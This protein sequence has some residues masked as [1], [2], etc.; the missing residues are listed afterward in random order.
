MLYFVE[1][2]MMCCIICRYVLLYF[3]FVGF[4]LGY[5]N[6][7]CIILRL[8]DF[9]SFMFCLE[10]VLFEKFLILGCY[11]NFLMMMFVL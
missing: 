6:L 2:V 3:F 4:N 11:G 8:S 5:M 7:R 10:N 9:K 1:S